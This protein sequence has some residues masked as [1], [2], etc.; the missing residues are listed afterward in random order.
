MVIGNRLDGDPD[1]IRFQ[2]TPSNARSLAKQLK[3]ITFA[4]AQGAIIFGVVVLFLNNAVIDG[5]P[6]ILTWI[7]LGAGGLMI[8]NHLVLPSLI[9]KAQLGNLSAEDFRGASD[10]DKFRYVGSAYRTQ[11]IVACA[12]LEGGAFFNLVAYMIDKSV[13]SV[14]AAAVL[15]VLILVRMPTATRIEF[16]VQDRTREIE[17]R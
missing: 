11:Q 17:L 16:W 9:V 15:V 7:A 14:A 1:N 5:E 12:L 13:Y 2:Q 8:V 6:D 3:I 10:E 4:L